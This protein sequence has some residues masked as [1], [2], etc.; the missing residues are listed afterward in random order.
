MVNPTL[1]SFLLVILV[2]AVDALV[3]YLKGKL[4]RHMQHGRE[5]PHGEFA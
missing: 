1:V 4:T 2:E 3:E 5:Y